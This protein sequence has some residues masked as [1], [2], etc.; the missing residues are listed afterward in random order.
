MTVLTVRVARLDDTRAIHRLFIGQIE[1][2]Q[3]VNARGQVE[4]LPHETLTIYER[5]LHGGVWMS[6]ETAAIHLSRLLRGAGVALVAETPDGITGYAE[7]YPGRE[8]EPFGGHLHLA[9]LISSSDAEAGVLMQR[10]LEYARATESGQLTVSLSHT[11]DAR[12][13]FF[14]GY[15]MAALARVQRHT[16]PARTGQSF[17]KVLD[18]AATNAEQIEDWH[19]SVGR[20]ESAAQHWEMLWPR[21]WEI[22]PEIRARLT[23]RLHF[24]ASGQEAFVCCQQELHNPRSAA[25]YC[26]SPKP[27]TSQ[28]L[29]AIRDWAYKQNYRT[30][31]LVVGA[32]TLKVLGAEAE[33]D[34]YVRHI[35][36]A[37]G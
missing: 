32:E 36:A 25:L 17:Y 21:L 19:M 13:A 27:L 12:A 6:L 7:A 35:Y 24:N 3:R 10:L 2:W 30:L 16:L 23:H 15:G 4:N 14:Q 28:L 22:M 20:S 29:I 31:G 5:W 1:V 37:K 8:P 34:P 9:H 18:H 26:W 33:A 11:H